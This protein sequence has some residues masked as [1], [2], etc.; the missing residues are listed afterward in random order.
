MDQCGGEGYRWSSFGKREQ[1]RS[2]CGGNF[3]TETWI[4]PRASQELGRI[5]QAEGAARGNAMK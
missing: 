2:L 3:Q 5:F 1:G 4:M